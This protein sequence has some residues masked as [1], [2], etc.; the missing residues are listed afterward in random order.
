VGPIA[1]ITLASAANME[2][3]VLHLT[4]FSNAIPVKQRRWFDSLPVWPEGENG[5]I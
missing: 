5:L 3:N 2:G 4:A 1:T